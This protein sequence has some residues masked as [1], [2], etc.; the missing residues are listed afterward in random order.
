MKKV[1]SIMIVLL[2][3]MVVGCS[4]KNN[5]QQEDSSIAIEQQTEEKAKVYRVQTYL[6]K[7]KHLLRQIILLS[8]LSI[9]KELVVVL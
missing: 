2:S 9:F 3:V 7:M 5:E 8:I 6:K 1:K 4:N